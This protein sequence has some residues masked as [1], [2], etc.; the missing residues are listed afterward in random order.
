VS[1]KRALPK[2][3]EMIAGHPALDFVNS[4]DDRFADGGPVELLTTYDDLL[5][6]VSQAELITER[7]FR[8]LKKLEPSLVERSKVVAQAVH[9]R[10]ALAAILYAILDHQE[11]AKA[12]LLDVETIFKD[13]A[14]HRRL[15]FKHTNG[16][17]LPSGLVWE[18]KGVATEIQSPVWLLAEA[19]N[20]L[21]TSPQAGL[22]RKCA[23]TTCQWLF[24]DTSKNHT[25]RW[26]DMKICGNR[27][28]A[29]RFHLRQAA[30]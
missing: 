25:R 9:L 13:A 19:A 8:E 20:N 5:R 3:F 27:N 26:C 4:I 23:S 1:I 24:L 30:G 16:A 28:K 21:L 7:Q 29:R 11:P 12:A 6:F 15:V 2:P 17:E 14:G 22:I 10:E 18:Y